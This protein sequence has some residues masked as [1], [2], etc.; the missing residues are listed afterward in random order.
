MS[1]FFTPGLLNTFV[2]CHI[3][4]MG[5]CTGMRRCA[6]TALQPQPVDQLIL[7]GSF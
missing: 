1:V 6:D 4:E 2:K 5:P 3:A 7:N